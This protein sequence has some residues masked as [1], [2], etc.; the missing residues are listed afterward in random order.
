VEDIQEYESNKSKH[1]NPRKSTKTILKAMK[2]LEDPAFVF[3]SPKQRA[4][5]EAEE[6]EEEE[7]EEDDDADADHVDDGAE[8]DEE[9]VKPKASRKR[10]AQDGSSAPKRKKVTRSSIRAHVYRSSSPG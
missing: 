3:V 6:E 8:Q 4:E 2:E 9:D 1:C 10:S 7:E 5:Q